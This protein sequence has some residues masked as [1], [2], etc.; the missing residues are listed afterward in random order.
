MIQCNSRTIEDRRQLK[1]LLYSKKLEYFTY[2]LPKDNTVK[3]VICGLLLIIDL[4]EKGVE[5]IQ[6][7]KI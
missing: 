7:C 3:E 5:V 4:T 6:I 1:R 2:R